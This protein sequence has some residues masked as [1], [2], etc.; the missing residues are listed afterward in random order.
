M[1]KIIDNKVQV[2]GRRSIVER[3]VDSLGRE[4]LIVYLAE[5]TDDVE[6]RMTAR[7][8]EI[9]AQIVEEL[10]RPPEEQTFTETQVKEA[11]LKVG[12]KEA[13]SLLTELKKK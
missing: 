1:P 9:E 5:A 8:T 3:H 12:G 7:A 10:N 6:A 4:H 13:T 2:D 11:Y